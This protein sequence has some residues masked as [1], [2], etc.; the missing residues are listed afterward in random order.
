MLISAHVGVVTLEVGTGFHCGARLLGFRETNV[1][2][3]NLNRFDEA[4][5]DERDDLGLIGVLEGRILD[6]TKQRCE[7]LHGLGTGVD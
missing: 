7:A 1:H 6:D 4:L 3:V 2:G 5:G